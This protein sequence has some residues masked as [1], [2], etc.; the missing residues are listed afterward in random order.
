[1]PKVICF[2]NMKGGVGKTT[3]CVNLAFEL[4]LENNRVL[5]VDNDPQF[6]ATSAL[7]DP[8]S[9]IDI[10]INNQRQ[11]TIYEIYEKPPRIR[12]NRPRKIDPKKFFNTTWYKTAN[13]SISLDLIASRI[14][15]YETLRNPTQK[16]YL[17]DKFLKKY[18]KKY[19]YIF[20]DCPPT[21]SVLTTSAFAASNYVMI[22]VTPDYFSTMGLPQFLGTLKD[23]KDNLPDPNDVKPLCVV[24]TNVPRS[25]DADIK[26]SIYRVE[27][28]LERI[29]PE[30]PILIQRMS[31]FKVYEKTLWQSVP[32]RKVSGKGLRGKKLAVAELNSIAAEIH[33]LME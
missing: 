19:D 20:I 16:E 21:P 24:F 9:Y 14:E 25:I 3:L 7:L 31:H 4:F 2:A 6:S 33:D 10:Y 13:R 8:K 15:V 26:K 29:S 18:A 5:I 27:E 12:G 1:M 23:F 32:V 30:V 11:N 17:L 22:P 28:A